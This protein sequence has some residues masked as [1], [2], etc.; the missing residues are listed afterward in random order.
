MN[1]LLNIPDLMK[2]KHEAVE[3]EEKEEDPNKDSKV[4]PLRKTKLIRKRARV[5][6][7][8]KKDTPSVEWWDEPLLKSERYPVL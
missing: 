8:V 6:V 3:D 5:K 7:L 2:V 1:N 4:R